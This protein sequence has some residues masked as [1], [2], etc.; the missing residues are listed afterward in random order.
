ML[1]EI[2]KTYIIFLLILQKLNP[3][4]LLESL[5]FCP[6]KSIQKETRCKGKQAQGVIGDFQS[7]TGLELARGG[8]GENKQETL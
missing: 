7:V 2:S 6:I 8:T 3:W 5:K 1:L 4:L